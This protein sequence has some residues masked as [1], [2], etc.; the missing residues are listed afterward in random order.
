MTLLADES[1]SVIGAL[2]FQ[3]AA[4]T[5]DLYCCTDKKERFQLQFASSEIVHIGVRVPLEGMDA[6]AA[7]LGYTHQEVLLPA[8]AD[9]LGVTSPQVAG[10][11]QGLYAFL[12]QKSAH[13]LKDL[14]RR[15]EL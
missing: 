7:V 10:L 6:R 15:A 4:G 9:S 12:W 1:I 3:P 5:H 14:A 11:A 2:V 8:A 13:R